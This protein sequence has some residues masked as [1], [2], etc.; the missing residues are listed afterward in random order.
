MTSIAIILPAFNE[1]L[2]IAQVVEDFHT[3]SPNAEIWVVDNC[4]TDS[5]RQKALAVFDKHNINGGILNEPRKGK[6]NALRC[7][8]TK[9][10]A[11]IYVMCDA[12][13][14]YHAK[15]M[16]KLLHPVKAG[17]ADMVIG[18]R[19]GSGDYAKEN[20]RAMHG[21]G[22]GLVRNL[23]NYLFKAKLTDILSGY[24]VFSRRFIKT[25]PVLVEGFE[26]ETDMT[27]HALDKRLNIVEIP[28]EYT[29]RP[30]G[31][32]SKLN[33]YRDGYRVLKT[34]SNILRHYRPLAFFGSLAIIFFVAGL[35]IGFPVIDQFVRTRL[36][37]RIPLA[38]L[39]TGV[40]IIAVMLAAIGTILDSIVYNDKR[41]F[42][43]EL[44]Q[45]GKLIKGK[46]LD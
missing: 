15:D 38:I 12:D 8:F 23:V 27:L 13:C 33:T 35:I 24:R 3:C 31:S 22:N 10:E 25:Y 11:D 9:V 36:I 41:M 28:I 45:Y 37:T 20:K 2:T 5:T 19:H 44:M 43:R 34:L 4:S 46:A 42:E 18:D 1:E 6:G 29:D 26:V 21:F 14:T 40:E 7:A 17:E 16:D 32:V 39:S 30:L